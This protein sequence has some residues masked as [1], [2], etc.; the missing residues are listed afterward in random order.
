[1][2]RSVRIVEAHPVGARPHFLVLGRFCFAELA[3]PSTQ[4]AEIMLLIWIESGNRRSALRARTGWKSLKS[5]SAE[6][7]STARFEVL[8]DRPGDAAPAAESPRRR[9]TR[10]LL[11]SSAAPRGLATIVDVEDAGAPEDRM[12][13]EF[14]LSGAPTGKLTKASELRTL[15]RHSAVKLHDVASR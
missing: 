11:R 7:A 15:P 12:C 9:D 10:G 4:I 6:L 14:S 1:L 3:R 13:W 2:C 5:K 8:S